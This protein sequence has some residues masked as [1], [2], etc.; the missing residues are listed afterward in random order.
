MK[1]SRLIW[2]NLLQLDKEE[3]EVVS[4]T[5]VTRSP[6]GTLESFGVD[7][8]GCFYKVGED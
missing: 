4:M 5:M 1:L 2:D 8:Y 7:G 3:N 6:D